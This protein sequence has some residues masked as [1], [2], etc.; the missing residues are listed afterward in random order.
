[1]VRLICDEHFIELNDWFDVCV[2]SYVP[3][4]SRGVRCKRG[5]EIFNRSE[6]KMAHRDIGGR[7]AG[8]RAAES[9]LD[10]YPLEP[11]MSAQES[12]GHGHVGFDVI[13][14]VKAGTFIVRVQDADSDH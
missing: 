6:Q 4:K 13:G 12:D 11:P 9:A 2:V 3:L 7:R 1:M 5:Q 14:N 8:A 10:R